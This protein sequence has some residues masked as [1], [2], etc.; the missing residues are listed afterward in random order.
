MAGNFVQPGNIVTLTAAANTNAGDVVVVGK[1]AGVSLN[2][3]LTGEA[4]PVQLDGVWTLPKVSGASTSFAANVLIYWN[5]GGGGVTTSATSNTLLGVVTEAK[6]NA[7]TS[8]KV[9]LNGVF[10]S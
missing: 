9:R 8:V 2:T 7:D 6:A 5:A 1:F 4:M 3:V 10:V